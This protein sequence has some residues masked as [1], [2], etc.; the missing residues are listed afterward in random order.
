MEKKK[1]EMLAMEYLSGT[2]GSEERIEFDKFLKT[3]PEHLQEFNDI[4]YAW[5]QIESMET[6]EPSEEMDSRFYEM[7][8]AQKSKTSEGHK[9]IGEKIMSVLSG[10]LRPQLAYGLILLCIGLGV[11]YFMKSNPG[12]ET[13]TVVNEETE[14]IRGELVLTL[15]EQPSANK[16]LQGVSEANKFKKA[17]DK[18]I[19][20]LLET[21]N[22]DPNVNVRLAAI[23]SLTNY[24]DNPIVRE[25]LVQS[26]VKQESPIVQV[27]LADLMVALQ[28]KKSVE[29]F[30]KLIRTKE[31]DKSV[32]EKLE[33]SIHSII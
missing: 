15:L 7:L 13:T 4:H 25:G 9:N 6:P 19:K 11:G 14:E 27:T 31:L 18:V 30:K 8:H 21:L 23:E 3:S 33:T 28:E 32:K 2:M 10:I 20:A 22:N 1:F 24:L 16:R 5:S 26:I 12:I 29:P 17:N